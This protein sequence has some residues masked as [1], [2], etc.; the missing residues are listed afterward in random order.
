LAKHS[1]E[2]I[3]RQKEEKQCQ[4]KESRYKRA[5]NQ[6]LNDWESIYLEVADTDNARIQAE[7]KLIKLLQTDERTDNERIF[8]Q[9][10]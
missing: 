7:I 6:Q 4:K 9:S 10:S 3:R 2:S 5:N 8:F 1:S